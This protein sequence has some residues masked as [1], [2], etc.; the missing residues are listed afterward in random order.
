MSTLGYT[1]ATRFAGANI[2]IA[3]LYFAGKQDFD[4]KDLIDEYCGLYYSIDMEIRINA[5]KHTGE[6]MNTIKA[7]EYKHTLAEEVL[8]CF[9]DEKIEININAVPIIVQSAE[10]LSIDRLKS[11]FITEFL[12]KITNKKKFAEVNK[13]IL[14]VLND[15]IEFLIEKKLIT[16]ELNE[17]L[18]EFFNSAW[19]ASD[20]ISNSKSIKALPSMAH[21]EFTLLNDDFSYKMDI[22]N[23]LKFKEFFIPFTFVFPSVIFF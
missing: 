19:K 18:H 13:A 4:I 5:L 14:E 9:R 3:S 8:N 16:N 17:S 15:I 12:N 6:I 23:N 20:T 21:L 22:M 1:S 10:C 2:I 7:K 11:D